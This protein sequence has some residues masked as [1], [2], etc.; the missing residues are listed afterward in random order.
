MNTLRVGFCLRMESLADR[1]RVGELKRV[2]ILVL[3]ELAD[4][5]YAA[6]KS[7]V[8]SHTPRDDYFAAFS[9]L[10]RQYDLCCVAGSSS[11]ASPSGRRSNSSFVFRRGRLVHRYDKIHLFKP[12]G[13][14]TFFSPG[15]TVGTF[16][17]TLK[18]HRIRAG[19]AIC[20]DLRFPELIRAMAADGMQ[21]LIVPARWPRVRDEAWQTLLKARAIEN[22]VFVLGCNAKGG[23]GGFSYAFDPTGRMIFT[24]RGRKARDMEFFTIDLDSLAAARRFHDNLRDAVLLHQTTFPR[25]VTRRPA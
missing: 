7:G 19:V 13:D 6:L 1:Q 5:G 22:Q 4:G 15:K 17:V 12:T 14:P 3:P 9:N 20:Y 10:T 21:M 2:D 11:V 8:P 16:G 18:G 23:E 25:T 24:N